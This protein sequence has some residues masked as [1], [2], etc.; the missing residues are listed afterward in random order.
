MPYKMFQIKT[1]MTVQK[2][3]EKFY[4]FKMNGNK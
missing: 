3:S 1:M 2:M 4:F